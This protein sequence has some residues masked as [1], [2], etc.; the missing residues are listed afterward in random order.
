MNFLIQTSKDGHIEHDF[1]FHLIK[2]CEYQN[3]AN[4]DKKMHWNAEID[5]NE[6][7][8][9]YF[10]NGYIPVGSVEFVHNYLCCFYD[11]TPKPI[12]I[13]TELLDIK[14]TG[15]IIFNGTAEDIVNK[16]FVKSNDKVKGYT[17]MCDVAPDGNYQISSLINIMSEWRVFVYRGKAVG[18]QNYSGEFCLFPNIDRINMMIKA[19]TSQPIAYTLDV[20]IISDL[21]TILIEVHNFY[22]CGLYGFCDYRILPF[23]YSQWFKE[24]VKK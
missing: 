19:Y 5:I 14:Y 21:S 18:L 7:N 11:V 2:S 24:C 12:N 4:N 23:M 3:W 20:G 10:K 9:Y 15:R 16:S 1:S 8:D 13:P 6:G 22:S 17:E